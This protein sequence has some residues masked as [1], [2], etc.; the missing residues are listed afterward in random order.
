MEQ[1]LNDK[2]MFPLEV[3]KHL[4]EQ[5]EVIHKNIFMIIDINN[6][7]MHCTGHF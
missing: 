7:L 3:N 4:S 6:S 2:N 5:V 1:A